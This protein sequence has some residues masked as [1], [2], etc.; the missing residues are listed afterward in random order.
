MYY[1]Q[2]IIDNMG[3]LSYIIGCQKKK[4]ACI[5]N[6]VNQISSYLEFVLKYDIEITHIFLPPNHTTDSDLLIKLCETTKAKLYFLSESTKKYKYKNITICGDTFEFGNALI[7]IITNHN[8]IP[9][10]LSIMVSDKNDGN[11]PSIILGQKSF[12]VFDSN[13]KQNISNKSSQHFINSFFESK[14][15]AAIQMA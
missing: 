1:K 15:S 13:K 6:P 8:Q 4:T 7:Q 2:M 3:N 12:F 10:S 14:H 9:Y 5:V 11:T